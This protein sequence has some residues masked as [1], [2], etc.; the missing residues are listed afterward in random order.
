MELSN[1]LQ[2]INRQKFILIGIPLFAL[3][4]TFF[5]VRKLP[6]TYT[7]HGRL[8]TGL[9]DQS[10]QELINNNQTNSDDNKISQQFS[11]L[12]QMMQL[13]KIYDQVSYQ[14]IIH[15]LTDDSPYHKPSKLMK[16][17]S[18]DAKKHALDVF[19]KKYKQREPLSL[20]D[21][22]EKGL[23]ELIVSM[24]YDEPKLKNKMV[25]YRANNSDFIDMRC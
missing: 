23:N 6:D 4:L 1:F 3:L 22:D 10:Q 21:A 14:L 13:K 7:S 25:I 5:L 8:A 11:N 17:L 15:D 20:W 19:T 18:K 2:L 12:I 16:D 9:I 24:G